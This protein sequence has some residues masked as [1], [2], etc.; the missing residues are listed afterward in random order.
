MGLKAARLLREHGRPVVADVKPVE[1]DEMDEGLVSVMGDV[2]DQGAL[3][4]P[5]P[6]PSDAVQA[7]RPMIRM[8]ETICLGCAARCF[9][10]YHRAKQK[11][12]PGLIAVVSD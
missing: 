7:F 5:F 10:S 2:T 11:S 12:S 3:A 9:A 6:W 8:D 4:R 1:L